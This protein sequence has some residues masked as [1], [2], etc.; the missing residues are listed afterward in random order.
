M[1]VLYYCLLRAKLILIKKRKRKPGW[2][3]IPRPTAGVDYSTRKYFY[4]QRKCR[5][6]WLKDPR[7][8]QRPIFSRKRA[9]SSVA[10]IIG[11]QTPGIFST[12]IIVGVGKSVGPFGS[13]GTRNENQWPMTGGVA[14]DMIYG[15]CIKVYHANIFPERRGLFR[16][17]SSEK[18][19]S[20]LLF[21]IFFFYLRT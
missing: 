11:A 7:H 8:F 18:S 5:R 1:Y 19:W 9:T 14:R 20:F 10:G 6:Y 21:S 16:P 2:T 13:P 15:R 4:P 3:R 17:K 12:G